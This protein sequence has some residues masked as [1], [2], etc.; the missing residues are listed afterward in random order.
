M[1]GGDRGNEELRSVGVF[2][3]I[4]HAEEK[5]DIVFQLE[6]FVF[7]FLAVNRLAALT[8]IQEVW[9]EGLKDVCGKAESTRS[10][11]SCK[12]A[13]LKEGQLNAV[14]EA[15]KPWIMKFLMIRWNEEPLKWSGFPVLPVPFSPVQRARKLNADGG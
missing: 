2:A 12:V 6:I 5:G 4:G 9:G 13:T 3:C 10:I 14:I 15:T 11:A 7:E 8:L 1:G